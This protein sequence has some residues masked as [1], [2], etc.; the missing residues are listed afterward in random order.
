[1]SYYFSNSPGEKV[2][3]VTREELVRLAESGVVVETSFVR[4]FCRN[5]PAGNL[6]FLKPVFDKKRET[7]NEGRLTWK[8]AP[9]APTDDGAAPRAL[10]FD[11]A[12]DVYFAP[13]WNRSRRLRRM[14]KITFWLLLVLLLLAA[15]LFAASFWFLAGKTTL[16]GMFGN[17]LFGLAAFIVIFPIAFSLILCR[18]GIV[19]TYAGEAKVRAAEDLRKLRML[20]ERKA[21][22]E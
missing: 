17:V 20:G 2:G 10:P 12:R 16:L 9:S 19:S 4:S 21:K 13:F 5:R 7:P 22:G 18:V 14:L 3:P 15:A 6:S 11:Y 1:M 8:G